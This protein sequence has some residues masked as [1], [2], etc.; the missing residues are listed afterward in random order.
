MSLY[1]LIDD[2]PYKRR[3]EIRM[4]SAHRLDSL[5]QCAICLSGTQQSR[6][7]PRRFLKQL[8][9]GHAF[10]PRCIDRWLN[11]RVTCPLCRVMCY[12]PIHFIPLRRTFLFTAENHSVYN[13]E[14]LD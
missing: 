8:P 9:C 12:D 14:T 7:H 4:V 2:C 3:R 6:N 10:H 5:H 1:K 11:T 13:L